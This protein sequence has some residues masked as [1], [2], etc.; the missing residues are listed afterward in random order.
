MWKAIRAQARRKMIGYFNELAT[1]GH[2]ELV[3]H[4]S[5]D[6]GKINVTAQKFDRSDKAS[7]LAE[8]RRG[9]KLTRRGG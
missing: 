1:H 9:M 5:K 7:V 6:T 3:V 8:N 4:F 2:G